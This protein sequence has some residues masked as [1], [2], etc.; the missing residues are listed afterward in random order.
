M[1]CPIKI[2]LN[3]PAKVRESELP[4]ET[5]LLIKKKRKRY[6]PT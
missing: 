5:Q 4:T 6:L 3:D 1:G 2:Y